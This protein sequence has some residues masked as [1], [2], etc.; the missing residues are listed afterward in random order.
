MGHF[1]GTNFGVGMGA[2]TKLRMQRRRKKLQTKTESG[3]LDCAHPGYV[4]DGNNEAQVSK[5]DFFHSLNI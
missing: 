2:Y 1:Y 5:R 4:K 3:Q